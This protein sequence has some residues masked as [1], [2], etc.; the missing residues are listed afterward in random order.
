MPYPL[1]CPI[2]IRP[3]LHF[4]L[5]RCWEGPHHRRAVGE[6]GVPATQT[7][8]HLSPIPPQELRV[9]QV[10]NELARIRIDTLEPGDPRPHL[11]SSVINQCNGGGVLSLLR[12][13]IPN[14]A[15]WRSAPTG[16]RPPQIPSSSAPV[17]GC[18]PASGP[19]PTSRDML[20]SRCGTPPPRW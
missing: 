16:S 11:S 18:P 14:E 5:R 2:Y 3:L 20:R 13:K 4:F 8:R 9:A 19:K 7:P 12:S 10:E 1:F 15:F 17:C 6:W